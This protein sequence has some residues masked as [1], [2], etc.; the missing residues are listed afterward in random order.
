MFNHTVC[1]ISKIQNSRLCP[2]TNTMISIY[3]RSVLILEKYCRD[4][5]VKACYLHEFRND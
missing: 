1:S 2:N 5:V 3:R 4:K